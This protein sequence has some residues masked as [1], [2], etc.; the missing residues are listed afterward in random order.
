MGVGFRLPFFV[1]IKIK[2]SKFLRGSLVIK[3]LREIN[4]FGSKIKIGVFKE[5]KICQKWKLSGTE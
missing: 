3:L 2:R 4:K 1:V 5:I